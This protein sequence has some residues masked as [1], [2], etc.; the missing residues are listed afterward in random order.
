MESSRFKHLYRKETLKTILM[1]KKTKAGKTAKTVLPLAKGVTGQ[2]EQ[3]E[4]KLIINVRPLTAEEEAKKRFL[5][6]TDAKTGKLNWPL[7]PYSSTELINKDGRFYPETKKIIA[8]RATGEYQLVY[9]LNRKG[10]AKPERLTINYSM[11][12]LDEWLFPFGFVRVHKSDIIS[13]AHLVCWKGNELEM[14]CSFEE[15]IMT[16][17]YYKP[18]LEQALSICRK[19]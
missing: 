9:F 8:I 3:K 16:G 4:E 7:E 2:D 17:D 18:L 19:H 14:H 13:I 5:P 1:N 10:D 15:K 12:Y 6:F 11:K